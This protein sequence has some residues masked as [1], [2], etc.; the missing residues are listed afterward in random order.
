MGIAF[1]YA[2]YLAVSIG[3][4]VIVASALSRSGRVYLA[5]V[6]GGDDGMAAAVNRMLVVGFCLLSLGYAALTTRAPGQIR[7][8]GQAIGVLSVKLGEELL[9]LGALQLVKIAL[10]T[11]FRRR[12]QDACWQQSA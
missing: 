5:E 3:L 11:R 2:A 12:R 1:V 4:T 6:F 10:V 8:P 7:G 9:V